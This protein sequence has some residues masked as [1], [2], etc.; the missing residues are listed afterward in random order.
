MRQS[1]YVL[2]QL[3]EAR[4]Y[5]EDGRLERLRL[6]LLLLDN[7]LEIQLN[8]QIKADLAYEKSK[9]QLRE[10]ILEIPR[11]DPPTDLQSYLAWTPRTPAKKERIDRFFDE[12]IDYLVRRTHR[13]DSRL[14]GPLKR[15]HKYRNEAYHGAKV[16]KETI[17]TAAILLIE[18]NCQLLLSL[19]ETLTS[20]ASGDDYSWLKERFDI[21]P[22]RLLGDRVTLARILDEIRSGIL[23]TDEVFVTALTEHIDS[24]FEELDDALDSLVTDTSIP[25]REAVLTF[26]QYL[27][28]TGDRCFDPVILR[29]FPAKYRL[30]SVDQLRKKISQIS[31]AQNRLDAFSKFSSIEKELEPIEAVVYSLARAVDEWIQVQ[32]DIARGK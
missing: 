25:D 6:G 12:K 21:E 19:P 31:A 14:A 28:E 24:R 3:D 20:Y 10:K 29:T 16:R 15:L 5:V 9:E 27:S 30:N 23:P 7:A 8:R 13:L 32:I 18:L 2:F 1:L 26:S 17:R 4:R 11:D 22:A